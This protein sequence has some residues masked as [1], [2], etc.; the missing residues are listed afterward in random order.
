MF[1][2]TVT[3]REFVKLFRMHDKSIHLYMYRVAQKNVYTLYLSI[4]LE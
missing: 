2:P 4:S 3:L 1:E